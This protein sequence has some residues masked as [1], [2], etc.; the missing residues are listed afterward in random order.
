MNR[1]EA[2]VVA[3][4]FIVVFLGGSHAMAFVPAS[5]TSIS[6]PQITSID[7]EILNVVPSLTVLQGNQGPVSTGVGVNVNLP[8]GGPINLTA[9]FSFAPVKGFSH[10]DSAFLTIV[11]FGGT[12]GYVGFGVETNGQSSIP[13][14]GT[15]AQNTAVGTL[16]PIDIKIGANT[17]NVGVV[18]VNPGATAST[19]VYQ[20]K[21]TIEYTYLG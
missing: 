14:R 12:G 16:N 17:I 19:F 9:A 6:T 20:L 1:K 11:Y 5:P 21:L 4:L 15:T 2:F 10:V 7:L 3:L 18:P 13:I 8:T